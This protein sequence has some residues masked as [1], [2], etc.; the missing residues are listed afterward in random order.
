[1]AQVNLTGLDRTMRK[2]KGLEYLTPANLMASWARLAEEDNRRGIMAGE[3]KDGA[4]MVAVTYRPKRPILSNR[5]NAAK[6][7]RNGARANLK[8]GNFAGFGPMA[9]GLHNNLTRRE[10]EALA[11]P[12]LAPRGV[13]SRVVTNFV[14]G[15]LSDPSRRVWT[16]VS[17]WA[18]V[19]D[20]KGRTFLLNH[21]EGRGHLPVRDL[22]G[23]RPQGLAKMRTAFTKWARDEIRFHLWG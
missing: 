11:G 20:T 7:R 22:R 15:W 23:V 4:Y 16:L 3:D 2:L 21:F 12:P 14:T 18:D 13:F 9:A 1:M 10:Y 5:G 17:G 8:R 19:V 6:D